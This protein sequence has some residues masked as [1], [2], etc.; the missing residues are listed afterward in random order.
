MRFKMF[1][2]KVGVV[3][4]SAVGKVASQHGRLASIWNGIILCKQETERGQSHLTQLLTRERFYPH[5]S[6]V[7][8]PGGW[9]K[10][11][12]TVGLW[13]TDKHSLSNAC[14][15]PAAVETL[16]EENLQGRGECSECGIG[17]RMRLG[18]K[19]ASCSFI[20]VP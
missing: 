2:A 16:T 4:V 9:R 1:G 11:R 7:W 3:P 14:V 15:C 10:H 8:G 17:R 20:K 6:P 5:S 18:D 19:T 13:E 12:C